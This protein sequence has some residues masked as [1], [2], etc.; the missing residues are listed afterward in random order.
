MQ[1]DYEI[2]AKPRRG[3]RRC[4]GHSKS[5]LSLSSQESSPATPPSE[6]LNLI[7]ITYI[8][9]YIGVLS[10][11]SPHV[12]RSILPPR[13]QRRLHGFCNNCARQNLARNRFDENTPNLH[14]TCLESPI[15]AALN[16]NRDD[17][18]SLSRVRDGDRVSRQNP[19]C[20][21]QCCTSFVAD[22]LITRP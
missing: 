16:D 13:P 14:P 8:Y 10:R 12:L 1:G 21:P 7:V 4:H 20:A 17:L 19:N 11:C 9:I 15:N 22:L 2:N 6:Q 18:L 3:S 5:S